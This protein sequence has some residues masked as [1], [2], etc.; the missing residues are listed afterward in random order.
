MTALE[1]GV[2][3]EDSVASLGMVCEE[4]ELCPSPERSAQAFGISVVLL[5]KI[6]GFLPVSALPHFRRV[7]WS[8]KNALKQLLTWDEAVGQELQIFLKNQLDKKNDQRVWVAVRA[9]QVADSS[10]ENS[11]VQINHKQVIMNKSLSFFFDEAFDIWASQSTV[12]SSMA[13]QVMRC[14]ARQEHACVFAYGQTGSGKTYTMFGD[15]RIQDGEGIA[16]RASKS[17]ANLLHNCPGSASVEFSFLEVY[18]EKVYDLL[19]DQQPVK[20]S[21]ESEVKSLGSKY[22]AAQYSKL[23]VVPKGL[24]RR[25]CDCDKLEEQVAEWLHEGA[26]TRTVGQTVFNPRS[27]RSHAVATLH[28]IWPPEPNELGDVPARP[29]SSGGTDLTRPDCAARKNR[30]ESRLYL[31]DLAGSERAGQYALSQGQL[32]EGVNINQ[33]LST[34]ARVVSVLASGK[35]DHVPFRD[36]TLTWLLSD[37]ITGRSA[38][39]FMVAAVHPEHAPESLSTLKYA[40]QYSTLQSNLS[41]VIPKLASEVRDLQGRVHS[42]NSQLAVECA[43]GSDRG[44]A[45]TR[46]SLRDSWVRPKQR[47]REIVEAHPYLKWTDSHGTKLSIRDVGV[48]NKEVAVPS[49]RKD[50]EVPDGRK[51]KVVLI[52]AAVDNSAEV[53]FAG[54][55]GF[56]DTLLWFPRSALEVVS[57]PTH[58]LQMLQ[59]LER[60]EEKLDMK[61]KSLKDAKDQFAAQQEQWMA[62]A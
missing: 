41:N 61:L 22:H 13:P 17:I 18:N 25:A 9:R 32:Q 57:K 24:T 42:L 20:L 39:T 14:I 46:E 27:S 35:G 30:K 23:F 31:V 19:A 50:G 10:A 6:C 12:W 47:A 15:P 7:S 28:I 40:Q 2:S 1:N 26:A 54:R 58:L 44:R 51:R 21:Y 36:S 60:I 56:P 48:I 11:S 16:F 45:W 37:A 53:I 59:D 4:P 49:Q 33:S 55:N 8:F 38:R 43:R 34:L 5:A 52:D 29:D 3:Q 62:T